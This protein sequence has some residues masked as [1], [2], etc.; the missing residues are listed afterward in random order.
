VRLTCYSIC[1]PGL[2]RTDNQDNLY[3][4]GVYREEINDNAVFR[5]ADTSDKRGLYAVADGMGGESHG[6][7]AAL[8]AV[9]TLSS[10]N[11]SGG[12]QGMVNY[13]LERNAV[14][15]NMIMM[16]DGARIGSTFVGLNLVGN[17]AEVTSIGDS[18]AYLMRDGDLRLL[19]RD[20][21]PVRQMV[22]LGVLTEEAAREHPDRHMLTQHLGIFPMEMLIEPFTASIECEMGDTFLLCSDG[23]TDMLDDAGIKGVLAKSDSIEKNAEAL[24]GEAIRN[25]GRDNITI[26]LVK[27]KRGSLFK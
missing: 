20:H 1:A 15:C 16:N 4:N 27:V 19:T 7:L 2:V 18:R 3:I 11:L 10:V 6:A 24:F 12:Q 13:L 8:V 17:R 25:G 5:Y 22:E 21:T 23:L 14:I 26:V 9:Q